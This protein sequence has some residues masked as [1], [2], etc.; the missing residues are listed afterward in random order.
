MT[1][2]QDIDPMA[3]FATA[4][5]DLATMT[6]DEILHLFVRPE[7]DL[8]PFVEKARPIVEAV[9]RDGDAAVIHYA[10]EFDGADLTK[11]GILVSDREIADAFD[12]VDPDMIATLEFAADNIR[13]FHEA[14]LPGEMWMKEMSRG[15]FAGERWTPVDSAAVYVPRGKGSFP[16]VA[17]MT[18]I[19][20]VVAKVPQIVLLTPA[21]PDGKAD[22]ATLIAARIAGV[23]RVCKAGGVVAVA[24]AAFG[25]TSIPRCH[26]LEGPGSPWVLAA[27]QLLHGVLTSRV[28][29]GPSESIIFADETANSRTA[30]LDLL[31]EA[32]HG[33]DSSAF[34]V[35]TCQRIAEE[36]SSE[37]DFLLGQMN[38]TRAGFAREVLGGKSGGIVMAPSIEEAYRFINDYAPE[39]LQILSDSPFDHLSKIRNASEILL[40]RHTPGSIANYVLGPNAVL[41]TAGSAR[42][43]A[44]LGVA[45][46]MKCA[47][48][49]YLTEQGY[50][51][52]AC[53]ARRFAQYEGF[54][55]HAN[56]VSSL[57][58]IGLPGGT[59]TEMIQ[60]G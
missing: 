17:L 47:S 35:T 27:K 41:P 40:G 25:T 20:A 51:S 2:P 36:A 24:A 5:H 39:H 43:Q 48:V 3:S 15:V 1:I 22:A 37:I 52:L 58:P 26:R 59:A 34:L 21:G 31:I 32:E 30:A 7:Q 60:R 19:P 10:K 13:R 55:A 23:E 9:R 49:G 56:A 33:P 4:F 38:P 45:D 18:A 6:T 46:F 8:K 14:Q 53:H 16:S 12:A 44:P 29:A 42:N 28:P 50:T 11:T 57:R 54:D